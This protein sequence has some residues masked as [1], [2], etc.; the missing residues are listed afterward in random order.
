MFYNRRDEKR[1]MTENK[2]IILTS[3]GLENLEKELEFLK[4]VKRRE[5]TEKI[6]EAL[7][8]GDLSEN[9]EYDEAR[10]EQAEVE[11]RV[12][13]IEHMLKFVRVLDE[14]DIKDDVVSLGA[15]VKFLDIEFDEV[16]EYLI[17]SP[18]EVDPTNKLSY[19]SP[20]GSALMNHVVGDI[21]DANTPSGII[22][23]KIIEISR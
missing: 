23:F 14:S 9:S 4:T 1:N 17:V 12:N 21:V 3:E 10:N 15:R 5:V 18:T 16:L 19:E 6:K 8:F 11:S 7:S 20:V 13:Q 22:Q 2:E